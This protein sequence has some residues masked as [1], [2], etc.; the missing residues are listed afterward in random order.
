MKGESKAAQQHGFISSVFLRKM[1]NGRGRKPSQ[2][3]A[4]RKG[5]HEDRIKNKKILHSI[6]TATINS[7]KVCAFIGIAKQCYQFTML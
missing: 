6:G 2:K 5:R 4:Y 1:Q 7:R 3:C